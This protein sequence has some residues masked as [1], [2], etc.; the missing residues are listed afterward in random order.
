MRSEKPR[1]IQDYDEVRVCTTW[2]NKESFEAWTQSEAFRKAHEQ[3][4][5][6]RPDYVLGNEMF[7]YEV[8]L[9]FQA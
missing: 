9:S 1:E 2:E 6:D 4:V 8:A 3:K 5:K 7:A